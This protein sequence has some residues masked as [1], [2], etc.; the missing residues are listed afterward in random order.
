MP[1]VELGGAV[2]IS[3]NKTGYYANV[4]FLTKPFYGGKKHRIVAEAFAPGAKRPYLR[5]EGAWNGV[6]QIKQD[7]AVSSPRVLRVGNR[8]RECPAARVAVYP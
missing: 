5:V 4:E 6:M 8:C 1:W 3:C 7:G 2:T